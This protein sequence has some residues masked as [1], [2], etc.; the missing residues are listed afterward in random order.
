MYKRQGWNDAK[1]N[2]TVDYGAG[3]YRTEGNTNGWGLGAMYELTYDIYLNENKSSILQPLFNASV[4][5]TRMDGYRETGAGSMGLN[6]DK[7]ELTT[8]TLA[9]GGRW[10]GLVGSNL[11]G[12]EALVE[13]RVN[14]AQDLG[15]RRGEANVGLLG[16]PGLLQRVRGAKVGRTAVQIG[17]GLS[18][19]VG[20]RGTVFVDGNAD[21]R[22]GASSVN[23]SIGY[24]YDF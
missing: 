6:V 23:G 5:T 17:A 14:A 19:P 13:L 20:T 11:F 22:N 3:S 21:I 10:M 16:N 4:V 1:L 15:D 7:Q 2:R 24:R 8:G 12:R 9:L 18:V